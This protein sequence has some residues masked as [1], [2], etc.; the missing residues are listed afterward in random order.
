MKKF[1]ILLLLAIP[2]KADDLI[3]LQLRTGAW[4][5]TITDT[6]TINEEPYLKFVTTNLVEFQIP[7]S[8]VWKIFKEPVIRRHSLIVGL[9][10]RHY[11]Q[12]P[13]RYPANLINPRVP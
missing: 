1:L 5:V 7:L 13:L 11:W 4:N 12:P 6:V 8:Q 10:K 3:F 9:Q 2:A